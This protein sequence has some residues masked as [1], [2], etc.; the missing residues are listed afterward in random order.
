MVDNHV[1][2]PRTQCPEFCRHCPCSTFTIHS[3]DCVFNIQMLVREIVPTPYLLV[4]K[5]VF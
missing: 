1:T 3:S 2:I 4:R 5:A